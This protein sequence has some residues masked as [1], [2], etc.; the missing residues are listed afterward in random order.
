MCSFVKKNT[1]GRRRRNS[2]FV[3]GVSR[4]KMVILQIYGLSDE[5]STTY[6]TNCRYVY[7]LL[8]KIISIFETL[9]MAVRFISSSVIHCVM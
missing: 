7:R 3:S 6:V 9:S 8:C 1:A 2:F 4:A 5:V